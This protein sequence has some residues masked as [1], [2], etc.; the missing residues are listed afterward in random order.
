MAA[1]NGGATASSQGSTSAD[2]GYPA[3][4]QGVAAQAPN[5]QAE[6][7]ARLLAQLHSS[8]GGEPLAGASAG[9]SGDPSGAGVPEVRRPR[10][11]ETAAT[12]EQL[13]ARAESMVRSQQARTQ[14]LLERAEEVD[15]V[16]R[17]AAAAQ[18]P[19]TPST[20]MPESSIGFLDSE[21]EEPEL[22]GADTISRPAGTC[23]REA[24]PAAAAAAVQEPELPGADPN[25]R[26]V[27]VCGREASPAASQAPLPLGE[28]VS[29]GGQE[30]DPMAALLA[31]FQSLRGTPT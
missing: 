14:M 22:P 9:A 15:T 18:R 29:T 21:E 10:Q 27:G 8:S 24:S 23:G 19:G 3:S 16:V 25:S 6:A 26:L 30:E 31:R 13:L 4:S 5:A 2:A 12:V 7:V 28:S 11:R 17:A 20:G 1:F